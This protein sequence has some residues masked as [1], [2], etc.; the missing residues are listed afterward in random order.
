MTVVI[1]ARIP[2]AIQS[3]VAAFICFLVLLS[4]QSDKLTART[5]GLHFEITV[6]CQQI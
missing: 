6:A 3:R 2:G 1:S 4:C 5:V